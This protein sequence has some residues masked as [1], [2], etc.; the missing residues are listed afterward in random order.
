MKNQFRIE[1]TTVAMEPLYADTRDAARAIAA[2]M[3]RSCVAVYQEGDATALDEYRHG[4]VIATREGRELA[5]LQDEQK[6]RA[7]ATDFQRHWADAEHRAEGSSHPLSDTLHYLKVH[8][9]DSG[10]L[11]SGTEWLIE[12]IK[13]ALAQ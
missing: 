2:S 7:E 6:A 10:H 8:W 5:R 1:G 12:R 13:T 3:V 9:Q 11:A 4:Q